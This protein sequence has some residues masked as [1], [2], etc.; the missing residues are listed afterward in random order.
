MPVSSCA[1]G[2]LICCLR[3]G[4]RDDVLCQEQKRIDLVSFFTQGC[5]IL[6]SDRTVTGLEHCIKVTRE[7]RY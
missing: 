1:G 7:H 3:G 4:C 5:L 2:I 6:D